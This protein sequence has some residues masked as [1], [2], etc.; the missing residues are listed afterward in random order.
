MRLY[1]PEDVRMPADHLVVDALNNIADIEAPCLLGQT[2]MKDDLKQEIAQLFRELPRV[3]GVERVQHF[4]CLFHQIRAQGLV[5]LLSVP[6]AAVRSAQA[7][8]QC[9]QVLERAPISLSERRLAS[10]S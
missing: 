10:L 2:R 6:G 1:G 5:G 7:S 9:N 3:A 4:I 8:L